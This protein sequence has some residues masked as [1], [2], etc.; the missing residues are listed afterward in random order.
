[1]HYGPDAYYGN[2][3]SVLEIDGQFD[4]LEE[5]IY[6]ESHLSSTSTK[7]YG[8][9]TELLLKHREYPGSNNGS[10]LF[11]VLVGLKMRATYALHNRAPRFCVKRLVVYQYRKLECAVAWVKRSATHECNRDRRS[12]NL[13]TT[14]HTL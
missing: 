2:E 14:L 11:Q 13:D 6:V 4:R 7:Y 9:M 8:E 3:V 10:G 1:M 5:L 12:R